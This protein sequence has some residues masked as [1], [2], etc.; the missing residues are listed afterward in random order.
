MIL[1]FD[2][3]FIKSSNLFV[4]KLEMKS[5]LLF[6]KVKTYF[7]AKKR[8]CSFFQCLNL[9]N[10]IYSRSEFAT[11]IQE[12]LTYNE[13]DVL[14][15]LISLSSKDMKTELLAD[16]ISKMILSLDT[17]RLTDRLLSMAERLVSNLYFV[18]LN[19]LRVIQRVNFKG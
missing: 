16:V 12:S 15:R 5:V 17:Q 13:T 8:F 11:K 7:F 14:E 10:F 18:D 9:L 1:S 4:L 6:F 2:L 19:F 3:L